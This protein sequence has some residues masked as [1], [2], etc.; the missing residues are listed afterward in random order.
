MGLDG[1]A[2]KAVVRLC[3]V[4]C[5]VCWSASPRRVGGGD[6]DVLHRAY[7]ALW[8]SLVCD[9]SKCGVM[10][11]DSSSGWEMFITPVR[12][13]QKERGHTAN[14]SGGMSR[15]VRRWGCCERSVAPSAE[16]RMSTVGSC[17]LSRR[18]ASGERC[19]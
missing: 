6:G 12:P 16:G 5:S 2:S 10:R 11:I 19:E 4:S 14:W 9:D 17:N 13:F 7:T 18:S 1:G 15:R 8:M 3:G